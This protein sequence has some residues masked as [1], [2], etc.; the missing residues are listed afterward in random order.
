[1]D[2]I[3]LRINREDQLKCE[4]RAVLAGRVAVMETL[5]EK[6]LDSDFLTRVLAPSQ[7]RQLVGAI[8]IGIEGRDDELAR[9]ANKQIADL[10]ECLDLRHAP[11]QGA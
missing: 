8:E 6:C 4:S 2:G 11:P 1:M 7:V 5:F 9:G 10:R 3:V